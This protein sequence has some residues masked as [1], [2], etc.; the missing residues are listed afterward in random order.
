MAKN[1]FKW[2]SCIN[3]IKVNSKHRSEPDKIGSAKSRK[4]NYSY[5]SLFQKSKEPW[6]KSHCTESKAP[7]IKNAKYLK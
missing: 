2:F 3:E 1:C 7:S 5:V 4:M 6:L